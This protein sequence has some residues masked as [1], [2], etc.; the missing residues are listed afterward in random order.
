MQLQ[1][2]AS[3]GILIADSRNSIR[4]LGSGQMGSCGHKQAWIITLAKTA[5]DRAV[6]INFFNSFVIRHT[7]NV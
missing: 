1:C 6:E 7:V 4:S 3:H 2:N 5:T